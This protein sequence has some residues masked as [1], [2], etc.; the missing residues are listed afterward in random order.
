MSLAYDR[1]NQAEQRGIGEKQMIKLDGKTVVTAR[2]VQV[3]GSDGNESPCHS[4]H[5]AGT[6]GFGKLRARGKDPV[7]R[8]VVDDIGRNA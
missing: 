3:A 7:Q 1:Q 8:L 4:T 5:G 2:G 6:T